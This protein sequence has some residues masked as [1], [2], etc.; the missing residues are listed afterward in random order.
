MQKDPRQVFTFEGG[1][2]EVDGLGTSRMIPEGC[3]LRACPSGHALWPSCQHT[4]KS[5]MVRISYGKE[6]LEDF[7]CHSKASLQAASLPSQR[8]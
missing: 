5:C 6:R 4:S 1:R 2:P 8:C 3:K 7:M